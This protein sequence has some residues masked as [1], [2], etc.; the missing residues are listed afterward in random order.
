MEEV[1][2]TWSGGMFKPARAMLIR[3]NAE[4]LLAIDIVKKLDVA[5]NFGGNQFKVGQSEL[6]MMTSDGN[7]RLG[8]PLSPN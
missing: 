1:I 3:G 5:V 8:I 7:H 2:P 4:L 6:E